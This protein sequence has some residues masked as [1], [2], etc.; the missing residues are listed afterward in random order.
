VDWK[1]ALYDSKRDFPDFCAG[2]A[3]LWFDGFER[4]AGFAISE[5]GGRDF[6]ILTLPGYRF[7]FAEI[8]SWVEENWGDRGLAI[9]VTEYQDLETAVLQRRGYQKTA[10][11]FRQA[12]DLRDELAPRRALPEGFAIVDM[13]SHPDFAGQRRLRAEAFAGQPELS[14]EELARQLRYYNNAHNG[15]IYNAETD[16]C[17]M[18]PDGML[19]AGCEALTDAWNLEADVERVCTHSEFRRRGFAGAVILECLH[20]LKEMGLRR[21]YIA[22]YSPQAIRLY[23]SLGMSERT[24]FY[25]FEKTVA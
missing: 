4:V 24:N 22:G 23:G 8:L 15:P 2:N 20:R 9:E 19:V 25:I 16:L 7:L 17:V 21:A 5:Y 3:Q 11:F 6:A 13:A 14:D 18:A 1:Y 10:D 12:F